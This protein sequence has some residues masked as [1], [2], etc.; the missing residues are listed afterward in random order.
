MGGG[1]APVRAAPSPSAPSLRGSPR[2]PLRPSPGP[3]V[4]GPRPLCGG[5]PQ[6][7][8]RLPPL[9][10]GRGSWSWPHFILIVDVDRGRAPLYLDRGRGSWTWPHFIWIV[11]VDR[12]R[13]LTLFGS[14]TW[15]VDVASLYFERGRR[16]VRSPIGITTFKY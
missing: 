2:A 15:I 8:V 14:W 4:G 3:S 10:R 1:L 9:D 12:G 7:P 6:A 5:P 11:D 13:G 16:S